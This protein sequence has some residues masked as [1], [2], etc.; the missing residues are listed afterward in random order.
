MKI[1]LLITVVLLQNYVFGQ[2]SENLVPKQAVSVFSINNISLLQKISLDDLVKYEFMEEVQQELF[3]GST[4]GKTITE[5]GID[6]D[7]KLNIFNGKGEEFEISG[8]SFGIENEAQF[9]SAFDDFQIGNSAYEGVRF[10]DSYF[11][12]VAIVNNS[13]VLF[14]ITPNMDVINNLTDSIWYARGNSYPWANQAV[15]EYLV[16]PTENE[17]EF[18]E[19]MEIEENTSTP[20]DHDLPVAD[21][22]PTEKTYYEL[23]DSLEIVWQEKY[24]KLVCDD[25]F[26]NQ[27]SLINV[28]PAFK[29]QIQHSSEGTFYMDN[30]RNLN[31]QINF[32]YLS[33]LYPRLYNDIQELYKGNILR[34]D[35]IINEHSID[36]LLDT[37]YGKDLGSI[38]SKL[39]D[40]KFDKNVGKYIHKDNHA[41]FTY[42]I[43][44]E[45]AYQQAYD[46]IIPMLDKESDNRISANLLMI[47]LLDEFINKEALFGTYKGS[48]F[49]TYG[50]IKKVKTKKIIYDYDEENFE[51]IEQEVEAEEDMPIFTIGLSTDR[52]DIPEKILKRISRIESSCHKQENIWMYDDA[53]FNAAP[54]Y[55]ILEND[56]FIFT[57]DENLALNHSKGF[58][59]DAIFKKQLKQAKNS[60]FMYGFADLGKA[61][62]ELPKG[63]FSDQENELLDVVRGK[64]GK[65]E[66]TTSE[67]SD[68]KTSFKLMYGFDGDYD[69]SGTYILDLINSL[70]VITK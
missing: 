31:K 45:E 22:D 23:R 56:L 54:L 25:L 39:M 63:L 66:F 26:L 57:N 19:D 4:T 49:G 53:L 28:A 44:L 8:I 14:R 15:E 27:Q 9:F 67:M 2:Q 20:T 18:T 65:V 10:F 35:L 7:Q 16:D 62:E 12:H 32:W 61:V 41:Y 51:Y 11:N 34:G 43:N 30:A 48:M 5:A 46:I 68:S 59:S 55:M 60:G 1:A 47:E 13:G 29:E 58:G 42:N 40:S 37:E 21:D 24:F 69:S 3:D 38:Y 52:L 70:Y 33:R 64:S 50:G 6:F 36:L 17:I